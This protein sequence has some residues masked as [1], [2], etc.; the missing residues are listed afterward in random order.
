MLSPLAKADGLASRS[1]VTVHERKDR[2]ARIVAQYAALAYEPYKWRE[3]AGGA[4]E[5]E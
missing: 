3:V 2:F 1:I 4:A 5:R